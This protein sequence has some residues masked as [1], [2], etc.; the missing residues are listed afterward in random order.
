MIQHLNRVDYDGFI[1]LGVQLGVTLSTFLRQH[2]FILDVRDRT[3][4]DFWGYRQL[5]QDLIRRSDL[6]CISSEGFRAWLPRYKDY[7]MSPNTPLR[8]LN[9]L[10]TP[11]DVSKC[12]VS[13]IGLVGYYKANV[14]FLDLVR[15]MPA[16]SLRYVGADACSGQI[17]RYCRRNGIS[18]AT[19]HGSFS[20]EEKPKFYEET[21]FTL[22]Y[23]GNQNLQVR[24]LLPNRLY[25]SCVYKRP[26]IVS[27]GTYLAEVVAQNGLGIVV[28]PDMPDELWPEMRRFYESTF[29]S[30]YISNC[31]RYLAAVS[32]EIIAFQHAVSDVVQSWSSS[33]KSLLLSMAGH[34]SAV[35]NLEHRSENRTES[36]GDRALGWTC[37]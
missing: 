15:N 32:E 16:I 25:E 23:W 27:H 10:I 4:E 20:P 12:V 14:E 8:N 31:E 33:S 18:N 5:A 13:Y 9:P 37:H 17:E 2:R 26:I 1:I 24:T 35:E 22:G 7:V 11:F 21:N 34:E 19:F 28:N 29:Y 6:T 3:Y 36:A 30:S